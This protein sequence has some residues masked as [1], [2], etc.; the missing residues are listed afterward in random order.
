M[1]AP[2][3]RSPSPMQ[4]PCSSSPFFLSLSKNY[5]KTMMKIEYKMGLYWVS[6]NIQ[7]HQKYKAKQQEKR[8]ENEESH[9]NRETGCNRGARPCVAGARPCPPPPRSVVFSTGRPWWVLSLPVR[10]FSNSVFCA[11]LGASFWAMVLPM[12]GHFWA[13]FAI[14]F[15]PHGPQLHSFSYYLAYLT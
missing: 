14:L 6:Y 4:N 5:S 11:C 9:E 12:L 3:F 13:S 7:V 10:S 2:V 1:H 15:D 8:L